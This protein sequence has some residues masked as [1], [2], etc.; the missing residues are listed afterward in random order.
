MTTS[1]AIYGCAGTTLTAE[2]RAFFRDAAPWGFIVFARNIETPDQVRALCAD[3][4]ETVGRFAPV[5]ID[6]EGGRVTRLKP[7]AFRDA[8]AMSVFGRLGDASA[9][10]ARTN[11]AL[12]AAELRSVGVTA[13]CVPVL[14]VPEADADPVIG[15]RALGDAPDRVA[16]L[17][18]A[19]MEGT[20]AGGCAPVIKHIPGHGRAGVD[21]HV[22]LPT[23]AASR[24]D[25]EAVD[26]A[27]FKALAD[28]PMAMTAHIVYSNIDV[29]EPATTSKFLVEDVI[30][31]HIGFDGLLMTDD[32]S[33]K[34]LGGAFDERARKSLAAG[35]DVVLHCNGDM[36]EMRAV[37][38]GVSVLAGRSA[39]R[40]AA[41]EAV[42]PE[43]AP[44][45]D[46]PGET[47]RLA[48]LLSS[49]A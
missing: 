35:C 48:G 42:I 20:M 17:G 3:L 33:M 13:N 12:L 24:A 5:F 9:D 46:V 28:A 23:V 16:A 6:Q 14:D 18:R 31:G 44:D 26:F 4:R 41:V 7:P 10:A 29:R 1:A 27:P 2:E 15:D 11:A 38:D 39:E 25:L 36:E 37:A 40:A 30:R 47:K 45:Y 34:A 21:S 43:I 19:V 22:A 49:L 8:P 32:L